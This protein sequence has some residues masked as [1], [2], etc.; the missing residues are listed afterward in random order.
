M[1]T[2]STVWKKC[3]REP[4]VCIDVM[5]IL[6]CTFKNDFVNKF[7]NVFNKNIVPILFQT[8]SIVILWIQC[9]VNTCT[10]SSLALF[11]VVYVCMYFYSCWWISVETIVGEYQLKQSLSSF[12]NKTGH[13]KQRP[14]LHTKCIFFREKK[15]LAGNCKECCNCLVIL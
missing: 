12:A 5:V 15:L 1:L 8:L 4:I 6:F 3:N 14:K 13:K 2:I 7:A 10:K 11:L 9:S